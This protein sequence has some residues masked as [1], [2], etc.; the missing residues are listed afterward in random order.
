MFVLILVLTLTR[1]FHYLFSYIIRVKHRNM[2]TLK[3][4]LAD[5]DAY[6]RKTLV[7]D[8]CHNAAIQVAFCASNG[9][10]LISQLKKAKADLVLLDL[11]MPFLSGMEAIPLIKKM[12]TPPRILAISVSYQADVMQALKNCEV[13]GYCEKDAAVISRA[14][15]AI[16]AGGSFFDSNY[17]ADWRQRQ[18]KLLALPAAGRR[19]P[20]DEL[21][22]L[23]LKIIELSC[24]GLTNKEIARELCLSSR[25]V[26][27]YS[28]QV[29]EKLGLRNKTEMVRYAYMNGACASFCDNMASGFCAAGN[30]LQPS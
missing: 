15:D 4:A 13:D 12:K 29:L 17:L 16:M 24:R 18:E 26:D 8:L 23:E 6:F 25:T 22:P 2:K 10:E 30:L 1:Y 19:Q 7:F 3:I 14:A 20:H 11:Y 28:L 21:K 27:A 9:F 5:D